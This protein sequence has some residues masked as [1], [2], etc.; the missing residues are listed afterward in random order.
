MKRETW[1]MAL[2]AGALALLPAAAGA[3]TIT[4]S[5]KSDDFGGNAG[6]C[7]LREAVQSAV[8]NAAFGGCVAGDGGTDTIV[9]SGSIVTPYNLTI[10]T[11]DEDANA[12]GDL[13]I[14]GGGSIVIAGQ[15]PDKPVVLQTDPD[16]VI[17][18]KGS[19]N[20]T[21]QNIIVK[22]GDV[23]TVPGADDD[24]RG[25]N[26]RSQGTNQLT[27]DDVFV[28]GGKSTEGGGGLYA[29]TNTTLV[30]NDS[31]II[32]NS[33]QNIGGGIL[34]LGSPSARI[35]R[36]I[37]DGNSIETTLL[38]GIDGAGIRASVDDGGELSISDSTIIDNTVHHQGNQLADTALGGGLSILSQGTIR[39]SLISGNSAEAD[40]GDNPERGGGLAVEGGSAGETLL[41]INSTIY[42][43]DTGTGNDGQGG[44]VYVDGN[45]GVVLTHDTLASNR[46][47]DGAAGDQ[48]QR[49]AIGVGPVT[50]GESILSTGIF[51]NS[52]DGPLASAG[53][54]VMNVD[55]AECAAVPTDRD[56]GLIGDIS[57]APADNGGFTK[58]ISLPVGSPA[59]DLVPT[60][61][62]QAEGEDQRGFFRPSGAACDAGAYERVTCN[63]AVQEG[64][65]AVDCP[66]L[67]P[68]TTGPPPCSGLK[69]KKRK[70]CLCKQKKN[71]KKRKKCLKKLKAKRRR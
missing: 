29:S 6:N 52:C 70:R 10:G 49:G 55:D 5:V 15:G 47:S 1:A 19:A 48:I 30:V 13:D 17:D 25:G 34:I 7:S 36:T 18:A 22:D 3:A 63:G 2:A 57:G 35:N 50:L 51:S 60:A 64:P 21:L 38:G 32:D 56:A 9:L 16:R 33:D 45:V 23:T 11:N 69:G 62:C 65:S 68:A 14:G 59:I 31:R 42:D 26:I 46:A 66:P 40:F 8:T 54:N 58:T 12:G 67:P 24:L 37:V 61:A 28:D 20:L 27:L 53:Y 39:R 44:G 71:K 41:V 43:N 4:P